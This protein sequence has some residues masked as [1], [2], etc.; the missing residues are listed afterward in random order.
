MSLRHFISSDDVSA[1]EQEELLR[2]AAELKAAGRNHPRPLEGRS[3]ALIFE[4][5][6]TRTRVS[7]D[8]AV[9]ELGGHPLVLRSDELQLGRGETIEDTARVMSRYTD[10]LVVRTFEQERLVRLASAASVP[11]INALSDLEH[12]CQALADVMTI[13]ER[14]EDRAG[15]RVVYLGDGN[16]VCHSLLLAGAKAGFGAVIAS[17]PPGYQPA[18]SVLERAQAIGAETGT[19]IEVTRDPAEAC[20]GAHVL[21]TDVWAS[22]GQEAEHEARVRVFQH[23]R[24]SGE[25]LADADPGAIVMHCL[26]A[27]R[28]E[29]IDEVIDG[30]ASAVWDQATNRLHAQKALLGW[31]LAS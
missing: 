27:H 26:P 23:Y 31:L 13:L 20:K 6:S 11:V 10:A 17:T 22:M 14:F 16:N 2:S 19:A 9:A 4:K 30:P 12:P 29:E 24:L 21:Y 28:G 7:F 18:V 3:V 5:P 15:L 25:R 1:A 8:V